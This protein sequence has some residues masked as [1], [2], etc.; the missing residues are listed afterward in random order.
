MLFSSGCIT[1]LLYA[2]KASLAATATP[3]PSDTP[4][5]A[6]PLQS[7]NNGTKSSNDKTQ[8]QQESVQLIYTNHTTARYVEIAEASPWA[9]QY[10]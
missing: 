9:I 2:L 3:S 10:C 5:A 7:P 6:V 4:L 1:L 8:E